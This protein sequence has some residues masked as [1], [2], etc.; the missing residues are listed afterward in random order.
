MTCVSLASCLT[1]RPCSEDTIFAAPINHSISKPLNTVAG[2]KGKQ[3]EASVKDDQ[4]KKVDVSDAHSFRSLH[5]EDN[6]T[7]ADDHRY[8]L[9]WGLRDDLCNCSYRACEEMI[10]HLATPPENE[11]LN[12]LTNYEVLRRTYQSDVQLEELNRLRSNCVRGRQF[13]EGL[14]KNLVLLESAHGQCSDRE[15]DLSDR[16]KDMKREQDEWRQTSSDQVEKI[17]KLERDLGPKSK[18]LSDAEERVRRGVPK[19]L[20]IPIG[21]CFTAGWLRGLGF[22]RE[23]DEIVAILTNASNLYIEVDEPMKVSPDVPPPAKSDEVGTSVKNNDDGSAKPASPKVQLT[24]GSTSLKYL[25][26]LKDVTDDDV[27]GVDLTPVTK[28]HSIRVG[29]T[30][31]SSEANYKQASD[32]VIGDVDRI[33]ER[34]ILL[35][36]TPTP[37][38]YMCE[39]TMDFRHPELSHVI[40][41][42]EGKGNGYYKGEPILDNERPLVRTIA[43]LPHGFVIPA[44]NA[45][46][47][48][49]EKPDQKIAEASEKKEKPA[50]VKM[51]VKRIREASSAALKKKAQKNV[52]ITGSGSDDTIFANP[53]NHS[54]LKPLKTAA[55]SKGKEAEASVSMGHN[56]LSQ[57]EL[58]KRYEQLNHDYMDPSNRSDVQLEELNRLRSDCVREGQSNKESACAREGEDIVDEGTSPDGNGS[59]KGC[60]RLHF[61]CCEHASYQRGVPKKSGHS[62]QGSKVW[63]DKHRELFTLQYPYIQKIAAY[64]LPVD[65]LM[66]MSPDIPPLAKSD[67]AGTSVKNNGDGS[68]NPASPKIKTCVSLASGLTP[69]PSS[70]VR[71]SGM[72]LYYLKDVTDDDVL[73][74]DLT[75]VTKQVGQHLQDTYS[76]TSFSDHTLMRCPVISVGR[77]QDSNL[78]LRDKPHTFFAPEE[79]PSRRDLNP[80][81]LA[82][83]FWKE[84]E[85]MFPVLSRMAMDL[86]SVQASSV[87]S[88]SAF[89]TSGRVL[90]QSEEQDSLRHF[91]EDVFDDEV[92]RNEAIPLSDK[93]IA[94]DASSAGTLSPGRPLYD[95]MMCNEAEDDY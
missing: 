31:S 2:S 71:V 66:K 6:D 80:R 51:N 70:D 41:D 55:G 77:M 85:T 35:R 44:K 30:S 84:K 92:Q 21:L 82:C 16:L 61:D 69:R 47:K 72:Y 36:K 15:R 90:C 20:V 58:L 68:A 9:N 93:E 17:K 75:P 28:Q 91:E 89:S 54:I 64:L 7:D 25:Y 94:L 37:L 4:V 8:I 42:S 86:I 5:D 12:S 76:L 81:L 79:K 95:Y 48:N 11:V 87:A 33:A 59:S 78:R 10:S 29:P 73:V 45:R 52:G 49:L 14:S 50:L 65:E 57:A 34:V 74:V 83:G 24:K 46:L 67:E 63:K 56:I 13:N 26:Y 3:A 18:Q 19:S 40:K 62:Y 32:D 60:S 39:L 53:I 38:L 1:P 43:L 22:G 23:E 88:E 27:L